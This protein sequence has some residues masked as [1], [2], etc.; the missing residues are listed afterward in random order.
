LIKF[1]LFFFP[2]RRVKWDS[3]FRVFIAVSQDINALETS[4][5]TDGQ[6]SV[7]FRSFIP[8]PNF[9]ENQTNS[10]CNCKG[11]S[12][13]VRLIL[14]FPI[15]LSPESHS[16]SHTASGISNSSPESL[17][18]VENPLSQSQRYLGQDS[19][20]T[21]PVELE[22]STCGIGFVLLNSVADI[23]EDFGLGSVVNFWMILD[24]ING[25]ETE[26]SWSNSLLSSCRK[27][28]NGD[29]ESPGSFF[30]NFEGGLVLGLH[31]EFNFLIIL[32]NPFKFATLIILLRNAPSCWK[33]PS[34]L[35]SVRLK[36]QKSFSSIK[37][38]FYT[39]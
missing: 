18:T 16:I 2:A 17:G 15:P 25:P 37:S 28:D 21:V 24:L 35:I 36:S 9:T 1:Y 8:L 29:V 34:F 30:E 32:L 19:L 7:S 6:I 20:L 4:S 22:V 5:I 38:L 13:K 27:L 10:T 23:S 26:V 33:E 31:G 12:V 11:I 3:S 39:F 14:D